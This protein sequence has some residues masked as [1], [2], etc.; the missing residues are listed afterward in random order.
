MI[1]PLP[2][3]IACNC[4]CMN[5]Y[6]HIF[7]FSTTERVCSKDEFGKWLNTSEYS[8]GSSSVPRH[9][10]VIEHCYIQVSIVHV[11][12]NR[13]QLNLA[14][15]LTVSQGRIHLISGLIR[16][17][18]WVRGIMEVTGRVI[19]LLFLM[20]WVTN[21]MTMCVCVCVYSG[22]FHMPI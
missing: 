1:W 14:E 8:E 18:I 4:V 13:F 21:W 2:S 7:I 22:W 19:T 11:E 12:L 10:S 3:H 9:C 15:E 5:T 20:D 16:I 6:L 17:R